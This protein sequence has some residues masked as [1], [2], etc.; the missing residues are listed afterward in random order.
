MRAPRI[1][2]GFDRIG[3][4]IG[5]LG[6]RLRAFWKRF[7][8]QVALRVK[9]IRRYYVPIDFKFTF[10]IA[11]VIGGS[12]GILGYTILHNQRD[13][14]DKQIHGLGD[15]AAGQLAEVCR[16]PLL[17]S[18]DLRLD[19]LVTGIT[20]E[21]AVLGAGILGI[22]GEPY[23]VRGELPGRIA[24]GV[25]DTLTIDR[26][27]SWAA[28]GVVEWHRRA[29]GLEEPDTVT[30]VRPIRF[31]ETALG[32]ALV[33]FDRAAMNEALVRSRRA[34]YSVTAVMI[35]FG[36]VLSVVVGRRLS[37][38]IHELV[39]ASRAIGE[40]D[41]SY[42]FRGRRKDEIGRLMSSFNQMADGLLAK[43]QVEDIFARYVQKPVARRLL[44][45]LREVRLGGR[46][47]LASVLFAD[48][49]GFTAL[50]EELEPDQV[51]ALINDYF[52]RIARVAACYQG[53][54]DKYIGDEAMLVFGVPDP[55]PESAFHAVAAAVLFRQVT[56]RI[57]GRR[58]AAGQA[59]VEFRIGVNAGPMLAGN[60]GS[61]E[62]MQYTVVGDAVNLASR[63]CGMASAGQIV[64]S[65]DVYMLPEVRS[66]ITAR[67]HQSMRLRGKRAP[68]MTYLVSNVKGDHRRE[69]E[70]FLEELSADHFG[71]S[72]DD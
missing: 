39:Q 67:R 58:R 29:D 2:I 53:S 26:S 17:A 18:D 16:E 9:P 51:A 56:A 24:G 52:S 28:T 30:F 49:V 8:E 31:E 13:L 48:I 34:I 15:A 63:L 40:G 71:G 57:S 42:R 55:D 46:R 36:L 66:R 64:I 6:T 69:M 59:A 22:R 72:T 41:L 14:I 60:M 27:P 4:D 44:A 19:L 62:H 7:L 23:A 1:K 43:S 37:R 65:S 25:S 50:S 10:A 20:R 32:Y 5:R 45:D 35:L 12:M 3:Q 33:T 61:E 38:P 11:L 54:V 21:E 47:V 68:V 70:H